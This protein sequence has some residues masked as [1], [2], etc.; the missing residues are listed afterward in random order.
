MCRGIVDEATANPA[1]FKRMMGKYVIDV[2]GGS[3]FLT[4]ATN[5][6]GLRGYVLTQV[7]SLV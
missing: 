2:V 4:E 1:A 3:G 5:H 7:W 6:L